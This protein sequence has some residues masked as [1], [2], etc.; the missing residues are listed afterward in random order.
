MASKKTPIT[1]LDSAIMKILN[2]YGDDVKNN[3][4]KITKDMLK[5]AIEDAGYEV[6]S[7]E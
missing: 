4:I 6:T 5:K 7:I 2:E 1:K 3:T